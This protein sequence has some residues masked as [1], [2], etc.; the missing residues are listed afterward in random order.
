MSENKAILTLHQGN[1]CFNKEASRL[2]IAEAK[3]RYS[4]RFN[5][6]HGQQVEFTTEWDHT[7]PALNY[8]MYERNECLRLYSPRLH[9]NFIEFFGAS[10]KLHLRMN[11]EH[12][13]KQL[14]TCSLTKQ[15]VEDMEEAMEEVVAITPIDFSP[16]ANYR[17]RTRALKKWDQGAYGLI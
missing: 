11:V 1:F 10:D 12:K 15:C 9:A 14:Y 8:I 5:F 6:I 16:E 2:I 4:I 7:N 13:E 17:F 3:R